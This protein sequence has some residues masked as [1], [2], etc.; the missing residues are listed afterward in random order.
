MFSS[1]REGS[2][3]CMGLWNY[4]RATV[5]LKFRDERFYMVIG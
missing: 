5:T 1:W 3:E 4:I 2:N